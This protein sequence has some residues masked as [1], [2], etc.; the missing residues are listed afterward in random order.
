MEDCTIKFRDDVGSSIVPTDNDERA[1]ILRTHLVVK[2]LFYLRVVDKYEISSFE[3]KVFDI[4]RVVVLEAD[5]CLET[6]GVDLQ[7]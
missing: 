3:V 5:C 6:S 7:V 1:I 2:R 4:L